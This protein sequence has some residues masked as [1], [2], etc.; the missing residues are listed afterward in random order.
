ML[1]DRW[2]LSL[3]LIT[4]VIGRVYHLQY[5]HLFFIACVTC[6]RSLSVSAGEW[7]LFT[8]I[9]PLPQLDSLCDVNS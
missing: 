5:S 3:H 7:L 9:E 8:Q 6:A 4:I 2:L 1:I